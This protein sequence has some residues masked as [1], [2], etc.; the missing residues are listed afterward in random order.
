M[1]QSS[2]I[3]FMDLSINAAKWLFPI[4]YEYLVKYVAVWLN[5]QPCLEIMLITSEAWAFVLWNYDLFVWKHFNET[6]CEEKWFSWHL[7]LHTAMIVS[8]M[9]TQLL[10]NIENWL[11]ICYHSC[12]SNGV[13]ALL[14][15]CYCGLNDCTWRWKSCKSCLIHREVLMWQM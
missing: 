6:E 12:V 4:F 15:Y 10:K 5:L 11:M 7:I 2:F 9:K 14:H 3:C 8:V 13:V 1:H